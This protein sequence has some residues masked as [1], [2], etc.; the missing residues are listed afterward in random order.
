[1]GLADSKVIQ[2]QREADVDYVKK[3]LDRLK[4]DIKDAMDIE[5]LI[6]ERLDSFE[7]SATKLKSESTE[8]GL[9]W[10]FDEGDVQGA[11]T[12]AISQAEDRILIMYPWIRNIDVELLKKFT[13]ADSRMIIQEASLDDESSV[14]IMMLLMKNKV[15]IR[16]MPYVH[17]VAVVS[18]EDHGL[19]I[20]TDPIYE[21]FEVGVVYKD[22]KSIEEIERLFEDAWK[23]SKDVDLE[24]EK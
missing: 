24:I 13:E 21:S 18:D 11:L 6:E 7:M 4:E 5:G 23:I 19:I 12:E 15:K 1:V 3:R 14:E 9:I 16:T 8:P 2:S 10:S 22:Q 17:T 20:S